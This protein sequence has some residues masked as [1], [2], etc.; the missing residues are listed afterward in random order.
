ML[1]NIRASFA[2]VPGVG[3]NAILA[4]TLFIKPPPVTNLV[5]LH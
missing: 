1:Y 3:L 2:G 5:V 4:M